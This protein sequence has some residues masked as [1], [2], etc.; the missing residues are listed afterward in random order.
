MISDAEIDAVAEHLRAQRFQRHLPVRKLARE[1]LALAEQVRTGMQRVMTEDEI[2]ER[3]ADAR[4]Q[5][6][7]SRE[8]R[9]QLF[10][11]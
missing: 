4:Q 11:K 10:E 7:R 1:V 6:K 3:D 2:A 9:R 8:L 5:R